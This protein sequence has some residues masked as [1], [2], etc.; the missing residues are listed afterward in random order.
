MLYVYTSNIN[1]QS[2]NPDVAR[3]RRPN[4]MMRAEFIS[5]R[6]VNKMDSSNVR[7]KDSELEPYPSASPHGIRD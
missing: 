2:P 6:A 4:V 3:R 1:L 5:K 7:T